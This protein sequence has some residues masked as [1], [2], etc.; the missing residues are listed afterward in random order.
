[1]NYIQRIRRAVG[2]FRN[3][4][5]FVG[6]ESFRT[7]NPY[8]L[9]YCLTDEFASAY[10]NIRAI[11]QE[12]MTIMPYAVDANG[13]PVK[14]PITDALYH[15]N[16]D[17]SSVSFFEKLAVSVISHRKT[18]VL[19][20]RRENGK[21]LPGGPITPKNVA[22]FTFLERPG[23][24]RRDGVTY[25]SVGTNEYDENDVMVIP[26][27]VDPSS[28]YSGYS[29][30]EASRKW[31]TLDQYIADYQSGFFENGAVP[32]GQFI[33]A[34]R[35][36]EDFNDM[37]D[38]LQAKHRGAGKNNNVTYS[39]RPIDP[40]NG[41]AL[42]S[43][44]EW[45]PFGESNKDIDFKSTYEQAN[46]RLDQAYGVS[47]V[48]K[49]VDNASTYA[50]AQVSEAGFSKRVVRPL[51]IRIYTQITHE[52]NRITGGMGM[53]I[54]FQYDIPAV[55]D[56][57]KVEAEKKAL[58]GAIITSMVAQG[59]SLDSVVDAF[60][61]S[62]SYKLLKVGYVPPVIDNDKTD[63]DEGGEVVSS[64]DPSKVDGYENSS[65]KETPQAKLS[66]LERLEAATRKFMKR[67]VDRAAREYAEEASDEV[68]PDPETEEIDEFVE[69][70][71]KVVFGIM[72]AKG[73]LTYLVGK[74][75]AE[76]SG[77]DVENLEGFRVDESAESSY[78]A[79]MKRVGDSYGKDTGEAIRQVLR[80]ADDEGMSLSETK[81]AL[82]GI[83]DTD[84]Y[85]V[86]R[87]GV[88]ELNRAEGIAGVDSMKQIQASANIRFE[89]A[90]LH[91]G[92]AQCEFC[93]ALDGKWVAVDQPLMGLGEALVGTDG[94]LLVNDFVE[95][96][97]Y[98]PHPNGHGVMTYRVVK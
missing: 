48:V 66:D 57:E 98:D 9:D 71:S 61:L 21:S 89:K 27:G 34:A 4:H 92:G 3:S 94:G 88:T 72:L 86:K 32:A 23:I 36:A 51:A 40:N 84:E 47:Q 76:D 33:V 96:V 41:K 68:N 49:G 13:K 1:M 17:D 97:G 62:N 11:S 83:M 12:F 39:H 28:L 73:T 85:R 69:S 7:R 15:P 37:V 25:Y 67:Q 56:Q 38:A 50:T 14:S 70:F 77:T 18:Y 8:R 75:L 42:D 52:L 60:Q 35:T 65:K 59:Y 91:P 31:A 55:S 16:R 45:V 5:S 54:T 19:V 80:R 58:E 87:M 53:A 26:G 6:A 64:P 78:R 22:G 63:V 82:K 81:K 24:S 44:I 74:A 43:Q 90:L 93:Q 46:N 30:S 95:N 10:P 29:P 20:W 2:A 79:Y